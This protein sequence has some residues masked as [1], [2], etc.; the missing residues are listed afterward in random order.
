MVDD[1]DGVESSLPKEG[2]FS[3]T[4]RSPGLAA[5]AQVVMKAEVRSPLLRHQCQLKR[6]T[7]SLRI[8]C[9]NFSERLAVPFDRPVAITIWG[10]SADWNDE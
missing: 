7:N 2:A 5:G 9:V 6:Q 1:P 4:R 3:I 10:R 8:V